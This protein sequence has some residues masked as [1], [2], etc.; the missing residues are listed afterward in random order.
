MR[1]KVERRER[2]SEGSKMLFPTDE[3]QPI[4]ITLQEGE[5]RNREEGGDSPQMIQNDE[6]IVR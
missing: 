3:Q 6:E 4:T 5:K 1:M 2:L